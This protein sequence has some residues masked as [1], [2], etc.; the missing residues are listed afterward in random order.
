MRPTLYACNYSHM[1]PMY[2]VFLICCEIMKVSI[3]TQH[4]FEAFH[5]QDYPQGRYKH[6]VLV[7][8]GCGQVP[9]PPPHTKPPKPG[10]KRQREKRALV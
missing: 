6:L 3:L 9:P 7:Q 5:F 8:P 4:I 1:Y 10:E 2:I